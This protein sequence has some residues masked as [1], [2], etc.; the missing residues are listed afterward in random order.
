[1]AKIGFDKPEKVF[2]KSQP[3]GQNFTK[4]ALIVVVLIVQ[5]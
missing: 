2:K 3:R 5:D 4:T 1:V